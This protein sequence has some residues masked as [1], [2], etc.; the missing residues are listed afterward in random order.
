M[1]RQLV[2]RAQ[3][4]D[5]EAFSALT[6]DILPR[7]YAVATLVLR[8]VDLASDAVQDALLRAWL[9]LPSLRDPVRFDPWLHRLLLRACYRAARNRRSRRVTEIQMAVDQPANHDVARTFELH[10][11][12]ER[13]FV[14]LSIDQPLGTYQS[15]L[16]RATETMR[17]ALE[18]DQ[19]VPAIA[20]E[21][22]R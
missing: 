8:D 15:R 19:R 22:S 16:R 2:E 13:G 14:R 6:A 9:D 1:K 20:P 10:D 18:A 3:S 21:M 4:G 11:Q 12:L 7:L 5:T 17:A